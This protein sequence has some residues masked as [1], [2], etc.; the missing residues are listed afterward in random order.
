MSLFDELVVIVAV[1]LDVGFFILGVELLHEPGNDQD[2]DN[3]AADYRGP[4]R[5][6]WWF[7][8]RS[9]LVF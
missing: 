6:M 1:L 5:L 3:L 9:L 4:V 8:F 7:F 2:V